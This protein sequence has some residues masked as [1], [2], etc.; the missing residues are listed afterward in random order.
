MSRTHACAL[1]AALALA[2]PAL[3]QEAPAVA[4]IEITPARVDASPGDT[5]RLSAAA[6]DASGQRVEAPVQWFT[7][8]EVGTIDST[9]AF[10][11]FKAGTR[12]IIAVAGGANAS[13]PVTVQPLPPA[14]VELQL[15]A[16]SVAA[17]S[18]L[19]LDAAAFDRMERRVFDARYDWSSS[20]P[21]V[22]EVRGSFLVARRPGSVTLTARAGEARGTQ[23]IMV[24][25]APSG[26]LTA[27]TPAGALTTGAVH[28]LAPRIGGRALGAGA[29]PHYSVTGPAGATVYP[30]GAFVA[31][32]PGDYVVEVAF[33][34]SSVDIPVRVEPRAFDKKLEFVG[35]GAVSYAHT[36]DLWVFKNAGYVG[37]YGDTALRV[38]DVSDPANPV[39]TDSIVVDARRVNDIKVNEEGGFAIMTREGAASRR[40]GIVVLDVADP[41]HPTIL[42]E[43]T[44]TVTGGVHNTFI[45][46]D[47]VY[48]VN[49]GTRDMHIIDVSDRRNPKEVG[50]WG[51]DNPN[52]T[53]H[54]VFI[55][56]GIA[57]LSYWDD[58]LVILDLGGA[59]KGGTPTAPAFVSRV[60]YGQGNTHV[61]WRWRDYVFVGDEIFPSNWNPD[62]P[63]AAS[64]YI[65]V[66]DVSDLEHPVEVAKFEVPEAGTHNV[67]IEDDDPTLY[68]GYYQAGLRTVDVSG[69]L[70]GE[71]YRQGRQ[72]DSYMTEADEN[73]KVPN[74]AFNWGVMI[75]DGLIFSADFNSGLW[76]HRWV[77]TGDRPIS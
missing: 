46:G 7:S 67:W 36:G 54:D 5:V 21:S 48:A 65:H 41:L 77:P 51:L 33:A 55:K 68:I 17:T 64:G 31:E 29:F 1:F 14:R 66:F 59:G 38:F 53:L 27:E 23:Q 15:P 6:F 37:N 42:S 3:A 69:E 44:E 22:A 57:Y 73:V 10:V 24:T 47:L 58:G 72:I 45:V 61:S 34:G 2:S 75:H 26:R 11:A 63:I 40:N 49:D 32:D 16:S 30:D 76:I 20:D 18:W 56:D 52:K 25:A 39:M 60:Y 35:R 8:Y 71:L 9:G 43:Y 28:R 62:K 74:A 19:P 50:R 70:R 12:A 4:R 13:V